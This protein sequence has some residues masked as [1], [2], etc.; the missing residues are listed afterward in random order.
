M[1]RD[2]EKYKVFSPIREESKQPLKSFNPVQYFHFGHSE[3]IQSKFRLSAFLLY[4][5][6]TFYPS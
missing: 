3:K 6:S 2:N 1:Q 4:T 5:I